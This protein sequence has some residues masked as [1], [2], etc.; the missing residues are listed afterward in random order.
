MTLQEFIS[1]YT[2][3]KVDW[4]NQFGAQCMDLY[5][6]YLKEVWQK[7]QT[8]LVTGAFQVFNSL[9]NEYE[10][11]KI[12]IP[13]SGDVITW[14]EGYAKNGHIAIV[15]SAD[16]KKVTVFEQNNPIGSACKTASH[17]YNHTIGWFRP[18]TVPVPLP[19]NFM[20]KIL[21]LFSHIDDQE[22]V[23][24]G[25]LDWVIFLA[26][27]ER[28][29][30]FNI[31]ITNSQSLVTYNTIKSNNPDGTNV[32]YADPNQI[33][34]EGDRVEKLLEKE[35]DAVCL[36]YNDNFVAGEKPNHPVDNPIYAYGFNIF[37][38]PLS[39]IS[40]LAAGVLPVVIDRAGT[41][42]FFA[43]EL[44]H[45]NYFIINSELNLGLKDKTH[46]VQALTPA[47]PTEEFGYRDYLVELKPYWFALTQLMNQA[48]VVK[49]KK[50]ATV[51]ICYPVPDMDYLNKK[52]NLE[53]FVVPQNIPD[54]DSL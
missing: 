18:V 10:K 19:I 53:G 44:S 22:K 48:K 39:W 5:R 7:A 12:G 43:H 37:S 3:K 28:M 27:D 33:A 24:A 21:I 9:E 52:A 50:S 42:H 51:Y 20:Q 1:K 17:S 23:T 36:I 35:F 34:A 13:K 47:R 2:S 40:N 30:G 4:D 38:I 26:S 54:T 14:D 15:V 25:I 11:I 16:S 6:F 29:K 31:E 41:Q 46:D 32:I 49:S 8:P 45:A